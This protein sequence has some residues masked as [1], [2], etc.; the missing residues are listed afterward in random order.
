MSS[1]EDWIVWTGTLLTIQTSAKKRVA[2]GGGYLSNKYLGFDF[3]ATT[4]TART[5][6]R[7]RI[8]RSGIKPSSLYQ[9]A[10]TNGLAKAGDCRNRVR[11]KLANSWQT[12]PKVF[13]DN[14]RATFWET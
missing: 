3:V 11:H 7:P 14:R 2:V 5:L 13:G 6:Q 4:A 9:H 8:C 1:D 10:V 12:I